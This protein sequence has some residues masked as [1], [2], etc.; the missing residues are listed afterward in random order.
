MYTSKIYFKIT[1]LLIM[2]LMLFSNKTFS[3]EFN[4]N[5]Q[6]SQLIVSGTSSLHDWDITAE[7]QKGQLVLDFTNQLQ[8]QKMKIEIVAESLKSGKGG[9]DKNTYKALNTKDF[10]N[11]TFQL[12]ETN[13]ISSLGNDK[14]KVKS[15]GNLTIAGVTKKISLDFNLEVI[16]NKI[17]LVGEKTF[18]MTQFG[19]DPP[20]ALFGTITTGDEISIKFNTILNK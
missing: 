1:S 20:K 14:Y 12:I 3:Q 11:I 18:K 13:D 2:T 16:S 5:N 9:M 17:K 8:I 7:Q 19:I 4:L 10:K 15:E 6:A